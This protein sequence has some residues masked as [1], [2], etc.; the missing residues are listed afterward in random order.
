MVTERFC[1][2]LIDELENSGEWTLVGDISVS[3]NR[4]YQ[5]FLSHVTTSLILNFNSL[6]QCSE[7]DGHETVSNREIHMDQ[8]G[9]KKIW[10]RFI[11]LY[12]QP[13]QERVFEGFQGRN[14]REMFFNNLFLW[15]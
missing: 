2:E 7:N 14:V 10:L 12:I 1:D 13:L 8:I 3:I 6:I 5:I 11:K 15:Q 9:M 4:H